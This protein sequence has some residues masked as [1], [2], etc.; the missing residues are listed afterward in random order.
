MATSP[1]GKGSRAGRRLFAAVGALTIAALSIIGVNSAATGSAAPVVITAVGDFGSTTQAAGVISLA[2]SINP[3]AHFALGDLSYDTNPETQWCD[4][5][6]SRTGEGFPFELLAGN[7][8]SDG[9]NGSINNFSAC[10]PNQLPGVVGTYGRQYYVDLPRST[11]VI[12]YI[13]VSAGLT[14]PEGTWSYSVGDPR[15]QW[16]AAAIDDARADGVPWVV[17]ANHYPC[18]GISLYGCAMP[19]SVFELLQA[20]HVD[21]V[22]SGHDHAYYRSHQ[23][24]SGMP[25]CPTIP[26]GAFDGD[27]VVDTDSSFEAGKG[28]VFAVVGT[29]GIALRDINVDD[30][31]YQYFA[32]ASGLNR[33]PSHGLLK[34]EAT[35][36][37]LSAAF[38]P[39]AGSFTDT[40][41]VTRV[42]PP[43]TTLAAPTSLR[44]TRIGRTDVALAWDPVPGAASYQVSR[45]GSPVG[46]T[47]APSFTD[48]GLLPAVAYSYRVTAQAGT[49]TSP[50]SS[51][52]AVTTRGFVATGDP[53]RYSDAGQDLGRAWLATGYD[54][55][56]WKSGPGQLGFG[57][58]DE[59][60]VLTATP[61]PM[62]TYFRM[63]FDAGTDVSGVKSLALRALV[64]DGAVAY[65]NGQEIW[66][67]NMP[68]GTPTAATGASTFI[69]GSGEQTWRTAT[70]APGALQAGAN[71]LAV[72]VHQDKVTSSDLSF[73]LVLTPVR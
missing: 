30:P 50:A 12:R 59:A 1:A 49:E 45:N 68:A 38:V 24:A 20:K 67:F 66:R 11:P 27:C 22:L 14:F 54:D 2:R 51:A 73:D 31:E 23:L 62:T 25:S 26:V 33:A 10:L 64:D 46:T 3:A 69:A 43:P 52:L 56:A 32:S 37:T 40:F 63:S 72:E 28:T 71:T 34:I 7:H 65:L 35:T 17:V 15:Y 47:T 55:S 18:L 58:G 4:F 61:R 19:R 48:A 16:L 29:G 36:E 8:E 9:S 70:L 42:A 13:G 41:T 57:D 5:V 21:L 39:S 44:A 60:T 53:W 6:K